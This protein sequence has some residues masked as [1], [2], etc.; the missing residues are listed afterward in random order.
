MW[1][2]TAVD[3]ICVLLSARGDAPA[4]ATR[5]KRG[6]AAGFIETTSSVECKVVLQGKAPNTHSS[7]TNR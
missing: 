4:T 6:R 1:E 7:A 3:A 5:T 2:D